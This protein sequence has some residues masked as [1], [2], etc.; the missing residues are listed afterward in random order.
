MEVGPRGGKL[1][2]VGAVSA[3]QDTDRKVKRPRINPGKVSVSR[4]VF[5]HLLPILNL[6]SELASWSESERPPMNRNGKG[7]PL[8]WQGKGIRPT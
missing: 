1:T 5:C 8:L 4:P 6:D 7:W 3:A 2:V